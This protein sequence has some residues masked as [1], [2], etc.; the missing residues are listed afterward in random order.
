M[1]PNAYPRIKDTLD[2]VIQRKFAREYLEKMEQ[3]A[4]QRRERR[5]NDR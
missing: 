1:T 3:M 4:K 5:E 2:D